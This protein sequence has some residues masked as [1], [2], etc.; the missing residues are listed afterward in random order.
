MKKKQENKKTLTVE[1]PR[2]GFTDEA[3]EN[4]RK[5]VSSKSAVIKKALGADELPVEVTKSKLRFSWF[6][7]NGD[8]GEADAYTRLIHAMCEMSKKQKRVTAKEK[9]VENEKLTMRLFLIRLGFIG[10][11]YKTARKLLLRN[12]SGNGSWKNGQPLK[13]DAKAS[14]SAKKASTEEAPGVTAD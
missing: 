5:I 11:E 13:D 6:T 7:L 1:I 2:E 4:L 3:I 9:P 12:L 14:D 8:D 10:D